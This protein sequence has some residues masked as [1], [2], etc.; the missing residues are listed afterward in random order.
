M[1]REVL[2]AVLCIPTGQGN[3]NRSMGNAYS[4]LKS[5]V[6]W[7]D[8]QRSQ[9]LKPE[10]LGK[11]EFDAIVVA[12]EYY[13]IDKHPTDR[14]PLSETAAI[15]LRARLIA[16]SAR[17]PRVLIVPGTIFY[18]ERMNSEKVVKAKANALAAEFAAR[19]RL[20][21]AAP[22]ATVKPSDLF[23]SRTPQNRGLKGP[24]AP[25]GPHIVGVRNLPDTTTRNNELNALELGDDDDSYWGRKKGLINIVSGL[26]S[27]ARRA[28]NRAYLLLAGNIQ[29]MCDKHSDYFEVGKAPDKYFFIPG[30][31]ELCPEIGGY[32][33]GVEICADHRLGVAKRNTSSGLDFQIVLSDAIGIIPANIAVRVGGVYIHA[34][35]LPTSSAVVVRGSTKL[36][37]TLDF[38]NATARCTVVDV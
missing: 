24:N 32:R 33:F 31:R 2:V 16:L 13:F 35:S 26:R 25:K 19:R 18:S 15:R 3:T 20:G 12:P 21:P 7:A 38:A 22:G 17:Y 28:R 37:K 23:G 29:G 10:S 11:G 6:A 4:V 9:L 27:D 5:V 14:L 36:T 34:S 1:S 30:T 8:G